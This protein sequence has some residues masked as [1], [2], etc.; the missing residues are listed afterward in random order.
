MDMNYFALKAKNNNHWMELLTHIQEI[1]NN[2][3]TLKGAKLDLLTSS[4]YFSLS[5]TLCLRD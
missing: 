1:K 2:N 5:L 4:T 3:Q